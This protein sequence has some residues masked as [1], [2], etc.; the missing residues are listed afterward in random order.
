MN[1]QQ[2]LISIS[3]L[4][5]ITKL[6]M[7]TLRFYETEFPFYL[8]VHKTAGGHRRY[9][10]ENVQRFLHLKHLIH[11]K[12]L[13]IREVKRSL[14]ADEDPQKIREEMDLLLKVTEELTRENQMMR[15]SLDDL[16]QRLTNLEDELKKGKSGFKWFK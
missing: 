11:E 3:E 15:K 7:S 5:E 8:Q 6:P 14:A 13:S 1:E 10:H 12:G 16:A 4:Q 2:N 9:S